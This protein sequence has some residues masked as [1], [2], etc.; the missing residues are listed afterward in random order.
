MMDNF[1][2]ILCSVADPDPDQISRIRMSLGLPETDPDPFV[3]GMGQAPD[4]SII[5]QK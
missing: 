4:P 2:I 5:K 1:I 3:P